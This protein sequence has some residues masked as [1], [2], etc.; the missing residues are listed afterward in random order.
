[1][2][3]K[4]AVHVLGVIDVESEQ[5]NAFGVEDRVLI[6]AVARRLARYLESGGKYLLRHARESVKQQNA[7]GAGA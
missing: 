1:M 4:I 2:P 3:I 5:P 6:E 7:Q